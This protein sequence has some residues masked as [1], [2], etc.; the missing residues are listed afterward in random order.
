M[1]SRARPKDG[2]SLVDPSHGLLKDTPFTFPS[3][4]REGIE[5]GIPL[6]KLFG[7]YLH[8]WLLLIVLP[9]ILWT[10][11]GGGGGGDTP[12]AFSQSDLT[13]SWDVIELDTGNNFGWARYNVSID[14]SGNAAVNNGLDSSG[15]SYS[16][17]PVDI[18]T[19]WVIN[20]S[21][22]IRE[23]DTSSS[24][25]ILS[26]SLYGSLASNKKLAVA[27]DNGDAMFMYY[28]QV[29][30]KRDASVIFGDGDI[31]GKTFVY[32]QLY[33][34]PDSVWV[35]G[36]GSID[37]FGTVTLDNAVD[38]A[39]ALPGYP[40]NISSL[41]VDSEGV[42]TNGNDFY[43]WLTLDKSTIFALIDDP[44]GHSMYRFVVI[45]FLGQTYTQA[46]L[47]ATWRF[48]VLYGWNA[49]GWL[50]G[51][52]TIDSAGVGTYDSSTYMSDFGPAVPPASETLALA[53]NGIITNPANLT[54]HGMMSS[55]KDLYVRTRTSG[56][57]Y[58][59]AISVK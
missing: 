22:T 2:L 9:M 3:H 18:Q 56:Q 28:L 26:P 58:S 31:R 25:N 38:P 23:Y 55:G 5:E 42:I 13:G 24:P 34:G 41:V 35:H 54:Y 16:G 45:Q 51:T 4:Q 37:L 46:D 49:P 40:Q 30:R 33:G 39:G 47:A 19:K 44:M 43:G 36:S 7:Q 17:P 10:C 14:G 1:G 48:H 27:T 29:A 8:A 32:H 50:K 59:I 21:G 15:F 6:R 52:W 20:G 57:R 12:P 11:G 53:P